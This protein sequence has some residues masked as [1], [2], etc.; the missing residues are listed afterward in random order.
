M[1]YWTKSEGQIKY[2][3]NDPFYYRG[4]RA[5]TKRAEIL[6]VDSIFPFSLF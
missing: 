5:V 1:S 4:K 2:F 6:Y 3:L